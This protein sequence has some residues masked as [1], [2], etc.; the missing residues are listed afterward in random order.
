TAV[1]MRCERGDTDFDRHME[2]TR[3]FLGYGVPVPR[4]LQ[5][6]PERM[7]ALFEDAGDISLYTYLKCP[8]G[9]KATESL[10]TK[11]IDALV[12][13]HTKATN[14]VGEC[15][16]LRRRVFDYDHFRWETSYFMERFVRAVAGRKAD[17]GSGIEEEFHQLALTGD[18]FARAIVHRDFQSQNVMVIG[19]E[20]IRIIDYQGA[21][22]GPPAYDIASL[23]WD[24]Y[25][26]L[27]DMV[28]G[29]LLAHYTDSMKSAAGNFDEHQFV[30][31]LLTCRLQRHMQALG[32]YGFLS[33]VKKKK[34]FL[35]F[36]DEGLWLLR[37][38]M[39]ESGGRY[40]AL[41]A[42]IREL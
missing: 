23:L 36:V 8:R 9:V 5:V 10:Y 34:H 28:R 3:F 14:H 39:E 19:G 16:S 17:G 25:H 7:E 4:L 33:I 37:E 18:S 38:D 2:Y 29:R 40:P 12:P 20:D 27:D 35:K 31:S 15:M 24:P 42:L 30:D 41:E 13:L 1:L 22:M 26:R 6:L 32:A 11:V 21:R